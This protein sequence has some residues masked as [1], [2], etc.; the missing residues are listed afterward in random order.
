MPLALLIWKEVFPLPQRKQRNPKVPSSFWT[1]LDAEPV[2]V[3]LGGELY[4]D[5]LQLVPV[6]G[7][8]HA[9]GLE[10]VLVVVQGEA[11]APERGG[12]RAFRCETCRNS[13]DPRNTA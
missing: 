13:A 1:E 5:A 10:H 6:F 9:R 3:A 2:H 11:V 8:F 4:G 12:R 7:G